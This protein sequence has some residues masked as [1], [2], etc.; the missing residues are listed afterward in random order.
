MEDKMKK[1]MDEME[2]KMDENKEEIQKSM[3]FIETILLQR[4]PKRDIE[5]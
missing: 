5:I 2:N 1:N 4:I 3:N